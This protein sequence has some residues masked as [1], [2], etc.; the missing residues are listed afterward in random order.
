MSINTNIDKTK[1]RHLKL[2]HIGENGLK[3]IDK[4]GVLSGDKIGNLE[5]SEGCVVEKATRASLNRSIH[6]SK[7][8]LEYVHSGLWGPAQQISLGGNS[9]FLPII[10]DCS[11]RV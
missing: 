8:K 11:K 1:L 10:N 9:Y 5:F 4:Q 2:G 3:E 7:D 6:K